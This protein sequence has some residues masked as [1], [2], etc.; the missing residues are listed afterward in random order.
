MNSDIL[1]EILLKLN[2]RLCWEKRSIIMFMDKLPHATLKIW[3]KSFENKS[4]LFTKKTTSHL[5]PLDHG[6]FRRLNSN[7]INAHIWHMLLVYF[8]CV[9]VCWSSSGNKVDIHGLKLCFKKAQWW[10][11][12]NIKAGLLDSEG[13]WWMQLCLATLKLTHLQK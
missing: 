9:Q 6:I 8:S 13:K 1:M 5:Q 3:T 2:R 10:N 11:A 7:I 4:A 12:F